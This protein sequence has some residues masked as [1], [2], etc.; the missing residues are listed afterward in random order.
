MTMDASWRQAIADPL[1]TATGPWMT[2]KVA[3]IAGGGLSGPEGGI[4]FGIAWL[5]ARDGANVAVLDRD[6]EAGERAVEL[7][8]EHGVE[9]EWFALDIMDDA[10]VREALTAAAERFGPIDLVA[11]SIGGGSVESILTVSEDDFDATMNL[12]FRSAW[13]VIRHAAPRMNDG[14]AIVTV[15]SGATEG[16]SP[17]MAYTLGKTAL[18]KLTVGASQSLASRRIRVN[19][20][21]VGMIWGAFAAR[22][23]SEEQREL[24]RQNV[25]MQVEGNAW[26]IAST[27]FFLLSEQARWVSGQVVA[28]DGGG[29]ALRANTGAAGSGRQP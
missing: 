20:V 25:A 21:R 16:R 12:N 5:C 13:S 28:V 29:F 11:D 4:G 26:D 17:G 15:S 8:R 22:G 6:R 2:G 18:E 23:M 3:A 1:A 7:L 10:S 14:G 24:R 9:A 27:A 19:C